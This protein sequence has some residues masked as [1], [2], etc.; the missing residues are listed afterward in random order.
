MSW[1]SAYYARW[2]SFIATA[3]NMGGVAFAIWYLKK[4]DSSTAFNWLI[5]SICLY[6]LFR[7]VS[8]WLEPDTRKNEPVPGPDPLPVNMKVNLSGSIQPANKE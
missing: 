5:A 7:V 6:L 4:G 1:K 3:F 8:E 2:I